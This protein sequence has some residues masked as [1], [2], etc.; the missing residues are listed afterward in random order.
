MA[1]HPDVRC[2]ARGRRP[3]TAGTECGHDEGDCGREPND[4]EVSL[5]RGAQF[6]L[7][8]A[9]NRCG[10]RQTGPRNV[11]GVDGSG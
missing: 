2:I 3:R 1:A 9:T 8:L 5:H 10:G 6:C 4:H 7:T 11:C